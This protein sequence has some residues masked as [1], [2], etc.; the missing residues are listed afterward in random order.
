MHNNK[1]EFWIIT[2]SEDM[3]STN[4]KNSIL[5]D[6]PFR[7][8]DDSLK[9]WDD[10]DSYLLRVP[11]CNIFGDIA[12]FSDLFNVRL[13][14]TDKR[15]IFLDTQLE[16]I[17]KEKI[18]SGDFIIFASRHQSKS[19]LPSI[20]THS[21]GNWTDDNS[22]GGKPKSISFTSALMLRYAYNNLLNQKIAQK[23]NWPVDLEVDHHG[24]TEIES[25]AIFMELGSSETDWKNNIGARAVGNAIIHTIHD[26]LVFLFHNI[27][28]DKYL[29]RKENLSKK[30]LYEYIR[31][32]TRLTNLIFGIGF[33]GPHYARSFS[34]IYT[35]NDKSVFL[36]HIMPKYNAI[37]SNKEQIRKMIEKTLEYVNTAIIDWKG[38]NS[39]EKKHII[40]L[41]EDLDISIKKTKDF[42]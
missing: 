8:A 35:S 10:H 7:I 19:E 12:N 21:T 38:L 22:H 18:F 13:V 25:P 17:A 3:A 31:S 6:Y 40:D 23:L 16:L 29:K 11:E 4:I 28:L 15:L 24:P 9:K 2:S 14:Q 26:Y 27:Q 32:N 41:I 42:H 1:L 30:F 39:G 36:S 37:N 5:N 33:G 34:K 20:L